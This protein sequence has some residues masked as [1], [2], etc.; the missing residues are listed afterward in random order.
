MLFEK[1]AEYFENVDLLLAEY[2]N[3]FKM[4]IRLLSLMFK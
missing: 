3:I 4:M 1:F 2:V